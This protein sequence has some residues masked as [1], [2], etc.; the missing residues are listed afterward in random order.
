MSNVVGVDLD[1]T[2][3]C[4]DRLLHELAVERGMITPSFPKN[5]TV[6]RDRVRKLPD[7][8]A[9]WRSLQAAMYGPQINRAEAFEGAR[10]FFRRCGEQGIRVLI[11]SHKTQ[12]A[13]VS[14]TNVDLK[15]AAMAW[16]ETNGFF[17]DAIGLSPQRDVFFESTR[18]DKI[19]R[20]KRTECTHFIDDLPEIFLES[21]FPTRVVKILFSPYGAHEH[22][23]GVLT[24]ARWSRIEEMIVGP[25]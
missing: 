4:Y 18:A 16:L 25:S 20:I 24:V 15:A 3:V 23:P 7:G 17:K 8:E 11:V 14:N 22:I 19:L 12:Y 6:I 10:R 9:A 21:G 13:K 2:I 1:N 5:K